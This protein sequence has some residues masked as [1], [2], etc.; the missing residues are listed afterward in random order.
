MKVLNAFKVDLSHKYFII[1]V[2]VSI[3]LLS[4]CCPSRGYLNPYEV[5]NLLTGELE[6]SELSAR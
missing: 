2:V 6:V 1:A 3:I 4:S 5:Q